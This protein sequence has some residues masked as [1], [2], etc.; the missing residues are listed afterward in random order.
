VTENA[1]LYAL[2][3]LAQTCAALAALVG[4]LGAYRIQS[5]RANKATA[6][7][8]LRGLAA[9]A[10]LIG[11]DV[12]PIAPIEVVADT[13]A[14]AI[15]N[16][17]LPNIAKAKEARETWNASPSIRPSINK[18]IAFEAWNLLLIGASLAGFNHVPW[19]MVWPWMFWSLWA[20]AVGTVA[21]TGY[22]VYAWTRG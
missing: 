10:N 6:E 4:A 21:V 17:S 19:L 13:V 1:V 2:S 16:P 20:A 5:L 15:P 3:T 18:F 12:A 7:R 8:D 22:C 14:R 11:G 9:Q